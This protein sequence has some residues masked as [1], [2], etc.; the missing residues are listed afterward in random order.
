MASGYVRL[1]RKEFDDIRAALESNDS[2]AGG[3]IEEA[4]AE[5]RRSMKA[6]RAAERRNGLPPMGGHPDH[7][8]PEEDLTYEDIC[9]SLDEGLMAPNAKL[10]LPDNW[11][12]YDMVLAYN[13][14]GTNYPEETLPDGPP[15]NLDPAAFRAA[16]LVGMEAIEAGD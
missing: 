14:H 1:T 8:E 5:H 15:R 4:Q 10:R 9:Q 13:V 12:T 11:P 2:A 6:M 7:P 16:V 3:W